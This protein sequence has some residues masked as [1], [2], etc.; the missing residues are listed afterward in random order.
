MLTWLLK[1]NLG[2]A[3]SLSPLTLPLP[4]TPLT[5]LTSPLATPR[6][7]HPPPPRCPLTIPPARG[8]SSVGFLMLRTHKPG[9]PHRGAPRD[10]SLTACWPLARSSSQPSLTVAEMSGVSPPLT[11]TIASLQLV[12]SP[13]LGQ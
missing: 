5:R 6:I 9:G 4:S 7:S 2:E 1:E 8:T 12:A 13:C 10:P 3:A 11:A